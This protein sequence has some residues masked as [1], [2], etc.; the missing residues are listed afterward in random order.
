MTPMKSIIYIAKT[1]KRLIRKYGLEN[2][3]RY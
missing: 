1:A 3:K 2:K